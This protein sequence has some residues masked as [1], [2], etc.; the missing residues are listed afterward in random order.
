MEPPLQAAVSS[1]GGAQPHYKPEEVRKLAAD[2]A[3]RR[4][5]RVALD[6]CLD[7]GFLPDVIWEALAEL[8]GPECQFI[9]TVDSDKR[10]GEKLD[11]YDA[12]VCG[13]QVY[14]KIKIV[15]TNELSKLLVVLSFKRNTYYDRTMR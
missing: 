12:L 3:A 8:D 5:T 14:V 13:T 2:P 9:K 4:V 1:P 15:Q 7:L 10:P 11:V 6:G